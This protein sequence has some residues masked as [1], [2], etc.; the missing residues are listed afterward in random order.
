LDRLGFEDVTSSQEAQVAFTATRQDADNLWVQRVVRSLEKSAGRPV[1]LLPNLAGSLPN[2]CFSDA[3]G[4]ATI[5][6]PHSYREC[7]QH[8]PNEHMPERLFYSALT[9]MAELFCDLGSENS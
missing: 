4:L 6:I 7:S 2:E 8:A 9:L 5:W 3:L 1:H